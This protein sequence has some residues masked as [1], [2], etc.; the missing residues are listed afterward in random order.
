MRDKAAK[1]S[2]LFCAPK[3]PFRTRLAAALARDNQH[4]TVTLGLATGQKVAES[5]ISIVLAHPVQ[6]EPGIDLVK[7]AGDAL[8]CTR[9]EGVQLRRV[10]WLSIGGRLRLPW[11]RRRLYGLGALS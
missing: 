8:S 3:I 6:V 4:M 7:A 5:G 11:L 1:H 9:I 10:G 2:P